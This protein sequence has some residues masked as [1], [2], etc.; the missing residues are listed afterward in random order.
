M[1][2]DDDISDGIDSDNDGGL[3]S[4]HQNGDSTNF[5]SKNVFSSDVPKKPQERRFEEDN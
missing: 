1:G 5:K 3:P 2:G 4:M